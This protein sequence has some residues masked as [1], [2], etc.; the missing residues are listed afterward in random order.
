MTQTPFKTQQM[1]VSGMDCGSCAKTIAASLQQLPGVKETKISFA[2]GR[3]SISYDQEQ[4]DEAAIRERI[5]SLGYT[6][7]MPPKTLPQ[8]IAHSTENS[9]P[10]SQKQAQSVTKPTQTSELTG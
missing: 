6:V 1:Q 7:D 4:V 10:D 5:T 3:L 9:F 8:E 2:T